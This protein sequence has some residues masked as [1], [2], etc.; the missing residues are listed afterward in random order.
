LTDEDIELA[1]P[2]GFTKEGYHAD[3]WWYHYPWTWTRP[4]LPRFGWGCDEYCNP[5][6]YLIGPFLGGIVV[7]YRRGPVR[8]FEDGPCEMCRAFDTQRERYRTWTELLAA[9]VR[10]RPTP[11][12]LKVT[13]WPPVRS[14]ARARDIQI[15]GVGWTMTW[16]KRFKDW[17]PAH[18][19]HMVRDYLRCLYELDG[20]MGL[21]LLRL[22]IEW[23]DTLDAVPAET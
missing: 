7:R 2:R 6:W 20:I 18:V 21:A 15:H 13:V 14:I 23:K 22:E 5:T 9:T 16:R 3:R 10:Q 4:W 19:E 8:R 12:P 11:L 17:D 1:D